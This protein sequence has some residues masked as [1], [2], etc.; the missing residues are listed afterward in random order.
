MPLRFLNIPLNPT[1]VA[2]IA[3]FTTLGG[4]FITDRF[5]NAVATKT[6]TQLI[7]LQEEKIRMIQKELEDTRARY[8]EKDV[9]IAQLKGIETRL[10]DIRT[11]LLDVKS[12]VLDSSPIKK[13]SVK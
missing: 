9:V 12:F 1:A 6:T 10:D 5:N 4:A 13:R 3:L 2:A 11:D 8:I 7:S